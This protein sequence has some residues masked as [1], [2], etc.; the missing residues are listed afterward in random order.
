VEPAIEEGF[1]LPDEGEEGGLLL[2]RR[3]EE[4]GDVAEGGV[5]VRAIVRANAMSDLW[6]ILSPI[7][8]HAYTG[9]RKSDSHG[10][11][12]SSAREGAYPSC[13]GKSPTVPA[14]VQE[15]RKRLNEKPAQ[16]FMQTG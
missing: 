15:A 6:L 13:L 10:R 1:R 7:Q 11:F 12:V 16:S 2:V 8:G 3:V 9:H 14:S 5:L 4:A